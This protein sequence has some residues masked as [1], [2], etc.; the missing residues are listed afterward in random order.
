MNIVETIIAETAGYSDKTAIIDRLRKMSYSE[1]LDAVDRAAAELKSSGVGPF[2]RVALM[3]DDSIDYIVISL[4]VLLLKAVIVPVSSSLSGDEIEALLERIDIESFIFD[5]SKHFRE[6]A[7]SVFS[8]SM[9]EKEFFI[10]NRAPKNDQPK[11]YYEMDPAFIRFSSGTT[12][13]SKGVVLSHQAIIQR[14]DAADQGLEMTSNDNIIWVLSMT[15]HFVV[16]VLLFLR[17]A[18]TIIICGQTF[19]DSLIEGLNNHR[20]TFIYASPFHYH[21]MTYSN[22]FKPAMFKNVRLAISTAMRLP[23][24]FANDFYDKFT[25]ELSEAYGII[26]V[27]LPFI[28]CRANQSVRGAVGKML[29]GYEMKIVEPDKEGAGE[30]FLRGPGLFDAYFSPWQTR[31][32]IDRQGWF[33]TGDLGRLDQDNFLYLVGRDK[34][35]INFTGMKIFPYEVE[36]VL[37]RHPAI[38]ESLVYGLPHPQY[39][40]LPAAKI[41]LDNAAK[42]QIDLTEIRKYCYRHLA[43]YKVPKKVQVVTDLKKTHSGKIKR[44]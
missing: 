8:D 24:S 20:A 18:A 33:H 28:N 2:Q 19:P 17:R 9:L 36:T 22:D 25:I 39:S 44:A 30:I 32:Q 42:S 31:N 37:N 34:D 21:M 13:A 4:A 26:E 41:V 10:W 40:Q 12:G 38:K 7:R 23:G 5:T 1:L 15:Y 14:T 16:T 3:C 27:G 35:V 11:E 29:P 6:N 43:P